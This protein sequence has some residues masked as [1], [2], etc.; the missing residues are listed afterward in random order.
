MEI[1]FQTQPVVTIGGNTFVHV[2]IIIQSGDTPLLEVVRSVGAGYTTKFPVYDSDGEHV[3]T[4]KGS[5]INLTG[6][7]KAKLTPRFLPN[8][9]IVELEGKPILDLHRNGAAALKG[10]A[11]L[12]SPDGTLIRAT[13][14]KVAAIASDGESLKIA[15]LTMTESRFDGCDIAIHLDGER[16]RIG[17]R[18]KKAG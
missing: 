17:V 2:P 14:S 4:V 12:Y 11:E 9:T 10:W 5:R 8:H 16:I 15:G 1:I 18:K 3:A 6:K 7:S 13:N